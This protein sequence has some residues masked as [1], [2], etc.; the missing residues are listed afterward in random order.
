MI[1]FPDT[2]F[3]CAVYRT[4]D[5][6]TKADAYMDRSRGSIPVSSLLLLEFR[7]SLRLQAR[8]F[9]NDRT[10]GFPKHQAAA[11][12][13]DFES[14]LKHG[15]FQVVP[16]D[17]PGVYQLAE[18]LSERHTETGGHRLVDLLHVATAL[19]LDASGFLSFDVKQRQLA[20]AEGLA[21]EV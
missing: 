13:R 10:K 20:E 19:H 17:W 2:S 5:N 7:Q 21:L 16:V 9:A 18:T 11:M 3:L 12:V 15:V 14:D 6:S 8:L 1:V 4:Q